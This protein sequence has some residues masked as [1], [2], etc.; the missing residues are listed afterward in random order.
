MKKQIYIIRNNIACTNYPELFMYNTDAQACQNFVQF[1][2]AATEKTGEKDTHFDLYRLG[3]L[4]MD[5]ILEGH[6]EPVLVARGIAQ[7]ENCV[8]ESEV[9]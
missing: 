4:G 6:D 9:E 7:A 2:K 1:V 5:N 8:L 3:V